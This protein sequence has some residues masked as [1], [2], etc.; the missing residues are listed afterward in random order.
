[1]DIHPANESVDLSHLGYQLLA[2]ATT[3]ADLA[4]IERRARAENLFTVYTVHGSG[5]T[6]IWGREEQWLG[7]DMEVY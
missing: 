2:I 5:H 6:Y 7:T 4:A 3:A 1:M